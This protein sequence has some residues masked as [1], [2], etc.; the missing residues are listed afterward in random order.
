MFFKKIV[1][2]L[3]DFV[4]MVLSAFFT[5]ALAIPFVNKTGF[6]TDPQN[7]FEFTVFI[8]AFGYVFFRFTLLFDFIFKKLKLQK[9]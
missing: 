8:V 5:F 4:P 1:S 6:A 7:L 9:K 2:G 3:I